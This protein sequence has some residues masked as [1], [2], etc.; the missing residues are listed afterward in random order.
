MEEKSAGKTNC[1]NEELVFLACAIKEGRRR[2]LQM[3]LALNNLAARRKRFLNLAFLLALLISQFS[4]AEKKYWLM[5]KCLPIQM[6][7][8]RK[9]SEFPGIP[10]ISS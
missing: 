7:D 6:Q 8:S 5:G 4:S 1:R 10:F 3:Q 2:R 9:P